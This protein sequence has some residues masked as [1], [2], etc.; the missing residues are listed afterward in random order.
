[1]EKM[2]KYCKA[3]MLDRLRLFSAWSEN[4]QNARKDTKTIDGV[5]TEAPRE[6]TE[7]IFLYLQEDFT[8]TDGIFLGKNVIFDRVTPEWIEFC[9]HTLKFEIPSSETAKADAQSTK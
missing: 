9:K 1:M 3:Y 8:V 2:G 5:E 7:N 4:A 6:L